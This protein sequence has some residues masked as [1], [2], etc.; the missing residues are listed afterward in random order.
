MGVVH[1]PYHLRTNKAVDRLLLIRQ[2][3]AAMNAD[4]GLTHGATYHSLAGPFM[5]D[6]RL[7]HRAFPSLS[8]KAIESDRQTRL[9]QEA[10]R[11]CSNL[12]LVNKRVA[13][14][15]DQDYTARHADVFWL[16][17]TDFG[18]PTLADFQALLRVLQ[19]GSLARLT[20]RA[21]SPVGWESIPE[22]LD[23]A[24]K[25]AVRAEITRAFLGEFDRFVPPR[26]KRGPLPERHREFARLVQEIV[27]LAISEAMDPGNDREFVHLSTCYYSDGTPMLSVTGLITER[28]RVRSTATRLRRR[29]LE[30]DPRWERI[31]EIDLPFLSIQERMTINRALPNTA[32]VPTGDALYELLQ[33]NIAASKPKSVTAL[34]QYAEYRH[35]YP[36]FV[37]LDL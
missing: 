32:T 28:R 15:I 9:R 26:A 5:E 4:V 3:D 19:P 24:Q 12:E 1:P 35:E 11:F 37:H 20:V 30:V 8:L 17:F 7:V 2:L 14:F 16:D 23:N 21:E 13:E 33:Y 6:L 36:S 18:L 29:R 27:R 31:E 22:A 25:A 34:E 10:H